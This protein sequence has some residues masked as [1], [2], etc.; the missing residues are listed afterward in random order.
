MFRP[1]CRRTIVRGI[2][3]KRPKPISKSRSFLVYVGIS[4]ISRLFFAWD[5]GIVYKEVRQ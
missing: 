1:P 2:V 5:V 3:V 4:G